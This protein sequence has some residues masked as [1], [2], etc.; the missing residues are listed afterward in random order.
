MKKLLWLVCLAVLF[1]GCEL[2]QPEDE[3]V[4]ISFSFHW[5]YDREQTYSKGDMCLLGKE[6][7]EQIMWESVQDNNLGNWPYRRESGEIVLNLEWW[8]KV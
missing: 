4:S 2:A 6:D 8:K 5:P 1:A 7:G 3:A